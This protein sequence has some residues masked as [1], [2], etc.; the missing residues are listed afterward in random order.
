MCVYFL[1]F[2][3]TIP[4]FSVAGFTGNSSSYIS[5]KH[6]KGPLARTSVGLSF[7]TFSSEG[8]LFLILQ[9]D[10]MAHPG[11]FLSI[12][13][14]DSHVVVKYNLGSATAT[15]SSPLPVSMGKW[16]TITFRYLQDGKLQVGKI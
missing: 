7:R 4:S 12:H 2:K 3:D 15:L 9:R 14:A 5:L 16:H 6:Q 8:L 11:D 10:D 13:L 1:N